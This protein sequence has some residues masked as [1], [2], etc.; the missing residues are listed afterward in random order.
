[1]QSFK[2]RLVNR[3]HTFA[4][5][6]SRALNYN[7]YKSFFRDGSYISHI[8][9]A[10]KFTP[11]A[12]FLLLRAIPYLCI[13][14]TMFKRIISCQITYNRKKVLLGKRSVTITLSND[15]QHRRN[16]PY[17]TNRH[18]KNLLT[19]HIKGVA[20][21][22]HFINL[23]FAHITH[24]NRALNQIISIKCNKSSFGVCVQLMPCSSNTL[25]GTSNPLRRP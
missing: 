11:F 12:Y 2:K 23:F 7:F 10:R 24:K 22:A 18:T 5:S 25:Q 13:N 21:D 6:C 15:A 16:G 14:V 4:F 17:F 9:N 1:M 20:R 3:S 8:Q 19:Q